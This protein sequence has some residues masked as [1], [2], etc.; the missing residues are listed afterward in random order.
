MLPRC[1][2]NMGLADSFRLELQDQSHACQGVSK[3]VDLFW[4]VCPCC[5]A[6]SVDVEEP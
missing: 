1:A 6:L 4:N 3:I 5:T 2:I